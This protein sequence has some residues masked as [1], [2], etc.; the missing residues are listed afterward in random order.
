MVKVEMLVQV[1]INGRPIW[2]KAKVMRNDL[3]LQMSDREYAKIVDAALVELGTQAK[4]FRA[5][6]DKE[7]ALVK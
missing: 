5:K 7:K 4:E 1:C 6:A 3:S 2:R